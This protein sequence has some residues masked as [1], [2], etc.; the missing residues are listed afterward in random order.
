MNSIAKD[1]VSSYVTTYGPFAFGIISL[2]ILWF[3]IM[4]PQLDK[5]SLDFEAQRT[6]MEQMNSH[7]MKQEEIVK[8]LVTQATILER[9]VARLELG[10]AK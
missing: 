2:L 10:H 1:V 8:G 9:V 3:A 4:K 7:A 6:I 5:Q